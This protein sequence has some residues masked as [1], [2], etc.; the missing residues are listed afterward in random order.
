MTYSLNYR[1]EEEGNPYGRKKIVEIS[2]PWVPRA[3]EIIEYQPWEAA[4]GTYQVK[5]YV[6]ETVEYWYQDETRH[7]VNVFVKDL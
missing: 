3:G 7:G 1:V 4:T 6:V 5:K 2:A